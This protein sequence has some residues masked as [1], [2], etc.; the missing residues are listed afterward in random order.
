MCIIASNQVILKT[1]ICLFRCV[2]LAWSSKSRIKHSW[3]CLWVLKEVPS[4]VKKTVTPLS[5]AVFFWGLFC[6]F[7]ALSSDCIHTY[8]FW[9]LHSCWMYVM[10]MWLK[11]SLVWW[12]R[13]ISCDFCEIRPRISH[14]VLIEFCAGKQKKEGCTWRDVR[15]EAVWFV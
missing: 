12:Q 8:I 4:H 6:A 2:W 5:T 1:L 14:C 9:S 7:N 3:T 10:T 11:Y 15:K 13:S